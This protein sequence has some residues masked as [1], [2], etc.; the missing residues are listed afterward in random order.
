MPASHP[1][2][3]DHIRRNP[4]DAQGK[5]RGGGGDLT[6]DEEL[7]AEEWDE[8]LSEEAGDTESRIDEVGNAQSSILG[9]TGELDRIHRPSRDDTAEDKG[10]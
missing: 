1:N 3:S 7:Q 4:Q 10:E 5:L 8:L 6:G 2:E 9:G